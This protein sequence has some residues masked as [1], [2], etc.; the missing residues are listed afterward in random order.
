MTQKITRRNIRPEAKKVAS[1]DSPQRTQ[2]RSR[3]GT[4]FE[5]VSTEFPSAF[6]PFFVFWYVHVTVGQALDKPTHLLQDASYAAAALS[7]TA[8]AFSL[9]SFSSLSEIT[10]ILASS[11]V[12]A[13]SKHTRISR[14][15]PKSCWRY[16]TLNGSSKSSAAA[17]AFCE[18]IRYH[19]NQL[20]YRDNHMCSLISSTKAIEY[21]DLCM[22]R[23]RK[24]TG[25]ATE[26]IC[27]IPFMEV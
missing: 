2:W 23:L 14:C 3:E 11:C 5:Y 21:L 17:H 18:V 6:R 26:M 19:L 8:A 13:R 10:M 25:M 27:G 1:S 15:R 20:V 9:L 16:R 4:S 24:G 7:H 12:Y 22:V